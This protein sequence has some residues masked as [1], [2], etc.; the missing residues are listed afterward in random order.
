MIRTHRALEPRLGRAR[1]GVQEGQHV[2]DV[3][4]KRP[5]AGQGRQI[6]ERHHVALLAMP[7]RHPVPHVPLEGDAGHVHPERLQDALTHDVLVAPASD[8]RE[9]VAE[10]PHREIRVFE[11]RADVAP[12]LVTG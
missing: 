11:L 6:P 10:Q 8:P 1:V 2:V 3:G 7:F 12:Q 9:H 5:C 4:P